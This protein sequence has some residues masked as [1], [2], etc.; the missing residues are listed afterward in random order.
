VIS[1]LEQAQ[2]SAGITLDKTEQAYLR[3]TIEHDAHKQAMDVC[4]DRKAWFADAPG[5]SSLLLTMGAARSR[6]FH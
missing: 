5:Q 1:A 3:I 4:V 2:S 6:A